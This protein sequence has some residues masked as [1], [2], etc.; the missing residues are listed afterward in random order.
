MQP[1]AYLINVARGK[2]VNR[3]RADRGAAG[4]THR[5]RRARLR[6]EEPLPA[7]S[8]LWSVPRLLITP[9]NRRRDAPL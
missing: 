7:S 3:A 1:S 2:V 4:R 9:H 8:A 5:R 6:L